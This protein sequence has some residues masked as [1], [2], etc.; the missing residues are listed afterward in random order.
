[1]RNIKNQ[2]DI[3]NITVSSLSYTKVIISISYYYL[4]YT[5]IDKITE[6]IHR[7]NATIYGIARA[8]M[9]TKSKN[10]ATVK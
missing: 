9:F 6:F 3:I 2:V 7:K 5:D 4:G 10:I 8:D 1:M